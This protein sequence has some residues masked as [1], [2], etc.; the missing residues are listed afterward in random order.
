MAPYFFSKYC[1]QQAICERVENLWR[2]HQ[3]RQAKGMG[4]TNLSHGAFED[5]AGHNQDN[6]FTINNGL[7]FSFRSLIMGEK[8]NVMYNNPLV[9][10]NQDLATYPHDHSTIDDVRLTKTDNFERLK[11]RMPKE[12]TTVGTSTVMKIADTDEKLYFYDTQGESMYTNPP[13][14]NIPVIDH[15]LD[16]NS[17]WSFRKSIYNQNII[18]NPY[19]RSVF[20]HMREHRAPWWGKKLSTPAFYTDEKLAKWY[21]QYAIKLDFESL[22]FRHAKELRTGDM[23][24][25]DSMKAEVQNFL[26]NAE[27]KM[28]ERELKDVYV[29]D[30]V[31]TGKK[32]STLN[33]EEDVEYFNYVRAV[34]EYKAKAAKGAPQ[35][36]SQFRSGRYELGSMQQVLFEPLASA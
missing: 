3:N 10:F 6:G 11:P 35:R 23:M 7:H 26:A 18:D 29:T 21:E 13:D 19:T 33:E 22:K 17:I 16:E 5:G 1:Y 31:P 14:P 15:G 32:F 27:K 9:R 25:R 2:I 28:L 4:A 34:E 12:G 30:H 24:Q 20:T 8:N 36:I